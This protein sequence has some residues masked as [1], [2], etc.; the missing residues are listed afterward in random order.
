MYWYER[1]TTPKNR[2]AL[3]KRHQQW[4]VESTCFSS[5][6]WHNLLITKPDIWGSQLASVASDY[7]LHQ[8]LDVWQPV[9]CD[10]PFLSLTTNGTTG[11]S[12][13]FI[14]WERMYGN[15]WFLSSVADVRFMSVLLQY[16]PCNADTHTVVPSRDAWNFDPRACV[17]RTCRR[18][19]VAC[20]SCR[21]RSRR[22]CAY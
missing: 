13:S 3:N 21:A 20:S 8:P 10:W 9:N 11:R 4:K 6:C 14:R 1:T 12:L 2:L 19:T 15:E 5:G 18:R 17:E 16:Q 7:S 22:F